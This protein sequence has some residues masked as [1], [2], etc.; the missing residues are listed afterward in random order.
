MSKLLRIKTNQT[1]ISQKVIS[2]GGFR[3]AVYGTKNDKNTMFQSKDFVWKVQRSLEGECQ[4]ILTI[5]SK[6]KLPLYSVEVLV[7]HFDDSCIKA[8]RFPV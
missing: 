2:S 5:F 3:F 6:K 1:L 4:A 7:I 8:S